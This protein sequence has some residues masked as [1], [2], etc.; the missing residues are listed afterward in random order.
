L[1]RGEGRREEQRRKE[2]G[3]EGRETGRE[4]IGKRPTPLATFLP[5]ETSLL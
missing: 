5:A 1:E 2:G 3:K 4:N